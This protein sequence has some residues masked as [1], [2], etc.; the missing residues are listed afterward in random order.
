MGKDIQTEITL[1]SL[2]MAVEREI[3]LSQNRSEVMPSG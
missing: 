1:M 3:C 2:V